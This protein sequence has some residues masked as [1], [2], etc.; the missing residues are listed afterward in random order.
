[1]LSLL[2]LVLLSLGLVGSPLLLLWGCLLQ[3]SLP[4]ECSKWINGSTRLLLL[5][6]GLLLSHVLLLMHLRLGS[7]LW[8][9]LRLLLLSHSKLSEGI[10]SLSLWLGLSLGLRLVEIE[11][12]SWLESVLLGLLL[13]RLILLSLRSRASVESVECCHGV[14][15]LRSRSIRNLSWRGHRLAASWEDIIEAG[16]RLGCLCLSY[17]CSVEHVHQILTKAIQ[18]SR[19]LFG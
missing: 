6:H 10:N 13:L 14:S 15:G 5:L 12:H 3:S 19:L 9:S 1:M 2:I 7:V 11:V 8:L 16:Q 4:T 17:G 18:R